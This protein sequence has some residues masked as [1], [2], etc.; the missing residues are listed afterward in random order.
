VAK[1]LVAAGLA[2][3]AEVE[4]SYAIGHPQPIGVSV[5]TFGTHK[6]DVTA[7]QKLVREHFDLSPKGIIRDLR[8]R[9]PI[10]RAT[11]SYGH[12]GRTDIDAPWEQT[13]K[14]EELKKAAAALKGAKPVGTQPA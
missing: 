11:A 3:R 13:N 8:L 14:A 7:I 6:I 9:R 2:D 10:Y 4:L 12:M 1:N 5:E